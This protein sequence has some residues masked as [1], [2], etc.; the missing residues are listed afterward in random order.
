MDSSILSAIR[1]R[2]HLQ[3]L[4]LSNMATGLRQG[5]AEPEED[6]RIVTRM[7]PL[8]A[9]VN[10]VLTGKIRDGKTIAGILWLETQRRK[11]P[12]E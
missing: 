2:S 8:S 10:D 12:R 1:A 7:F 3:S 9:L 6:E 4:F 5:E 11:Q